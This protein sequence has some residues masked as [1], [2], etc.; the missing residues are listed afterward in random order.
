MIGEG[1]GEEEEEEEEG[2]GE[3]ERGHGRGAW[4]YGDQRQL[5]SEIGTDS[6]LVRLPSLH[7]S[8]L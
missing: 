5:R 1:G 4:V 3:G 8:R 2:G 6:V 7:V